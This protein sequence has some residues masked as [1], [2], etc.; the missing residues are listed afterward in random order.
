[1]KLF[2]SL[3]VVMTVLFTLL[4]CIDQIQIVLKVT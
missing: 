3:Q 2:M 4:L 1:M